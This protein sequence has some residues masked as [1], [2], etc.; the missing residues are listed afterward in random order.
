MSNGIFKSTITD[1]Q[2]L[3]EQ[4]IIAILNDAAFAAE[5]YAKAQIVANNT[6]D[7]GFMANSTHGIPVGSSGIRG[8]TQRL[9]DKHGNMVRRTSTDLPAMDALTSAIGCGAEYAAKVEMRKPFLQPAADRVKQGIGA[10]IQAHQ[11]D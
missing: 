6:I 3:T 2:N 11:V 1:V 7:T 10:I 5:G 9:A 4:Q 8:E